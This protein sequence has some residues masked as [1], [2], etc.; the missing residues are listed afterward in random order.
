M[1]RPIST[2]KYGGSE[3]VIAISTGEV[4]E[5][6]LPPQVLGLVQEWRE[7]HTIELADDWN[8]ARDR[9][10]LKD[11]DRF[12]EFVLDKELETIVWPNGADFAPEFL[13]QLLR[14]DYTLKSSSDA[15]TT[16]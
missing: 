13:Y 6:R 7:Y 14:P 9:K 16:Q 12:R 10:P 2:Q 1:F 11:K 3:A 4:I 8:L 5:G 15:S